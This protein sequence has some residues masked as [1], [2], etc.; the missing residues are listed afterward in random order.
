MLSLLAA[1]AI[2]PIAY[3][4]P[5]GASNDYFVRVG[6]D[7]FLPLMGGREGKVQVDLT[8]NVKGLSESQTAPKASS[9]ITAFKLLFNGAEFPMAL[10]SVKGYFPKTTIG[11]TPEGRVVSTDAPDVAL[12]VRLPGLDAKR[13]PDVTF[14]PVE[15]PVGGIEEG[16][17]W[18]YKKPFGD[19]E[20]TFTVTPAQI[21]EGEAKLKV[22]LV[23]HYDT[24][25]DS[26][27]GVVTEESQA[28]SKVS[29]DVLGHGTAV[30]DRKKG[31]VSAFELKADATSEVTNLKSKAKS[32]RKLS[33]KV[34]VS[35]DKPLA[36][37]PGNGAG[38]SGLLNLLQNKLPKGET[39]QRAVVATQ[40]M[41]PTARDWKRAV[42]LVVS[43]V[44]H[45]N[46]VSQ[47]AIRRQGDQL[48]VLA[49]QAAS[50]VPKLLDVKAVKS[51][52]GVIRRVP[53]VVRS[54]AGPDYERA[55]RLAHQFVQNL[56]LHDPSAP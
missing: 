42:P 41:H 31:L 5:A 3:A 20:V 19:S 37:A 17:S 56:F 29:T 32:T 27:M 33:T 46:V 4:F 49:R 53:S 6:F 44:N 55:Y 47:Q 2:V 16:K 22:D 9:D 52:G 43:T 8:L 51:L 34:E 21:Q 40:L 50:G 18:T 38:G 48:A 25:E 11:M 39:V 30:F 7:G 24:L 10:E 1:S 23:Q 26:A 15:F 12:P 45:V 13:F 35:L 14:L 28:E 54:H 36:S